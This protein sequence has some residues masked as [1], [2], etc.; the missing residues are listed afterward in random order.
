MKSKKNNLM[1]RI[2]ICKKCNSSLNFKGNIY[3]C[4]KCGDQMYLKDDII[5]YL[6]RKLKNYKLELKNEKTFGYEW[7]KFEKWGFYNLKRTD[8]NYSEYHGGT[9]D[10]TRKAFKSKCRLDF[11]EIKNK[12]VMD[13]G[14]GNGRYTNEAMR[15]AKSNC[16]IISVDASLEALKVAKKNNKQNI[17]K[18]IFINASLDDLPIKPNSVDSVFSN[19][20][21][22]HTINPYN[23]F[24]EITRVLKKKGTIVINVY[25]KLNIF[26]EIINK[27]IRLVTTKLDNRSNIIFSKLMSNVAI[28]IK[29]IPKLLEFFNIF[30]RI[31]TTSHHMF[32]WYS[33]QIVHHHELVEIKSWFKKRKIKI[34]DNFKNYNKSYLKRKWAINIKGKKK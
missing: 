14:C 13:A 11:R 5:Y 16:Y 12:I 32:D 33:A 7:K 28:I 23:S 2:L 19:G 3:S 20:V 6:K 29:K 22:M 10:D 8:N 30:F 9:V 15:I 1:L 24:K 21:L 18:I 27:I 26:F 31:Q 17:N 25:Q 34:L 4:K